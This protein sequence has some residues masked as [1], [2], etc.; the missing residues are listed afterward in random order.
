MKRVFTG[1]AAVLFLAV[2]AQFFLAA[3]GAFDSAPTEEAFQPHRVLGYSIFV[4]A[5]VVTVVGAIA[6]MPRR[7][8]GIAGLAVVLVLVQV[9]IAEVAKAF[10]DGSTA[11]HLIF[12]LHAVNGLLT[13]GATETVVQRTRKVTV[14]PA[15]PSRVAT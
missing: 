1:L 15:E 13:M 6:Q 9:M 12:G 8:V 3:S 10:G 11:G 5:V 2:V 4:L 14:K 7:I